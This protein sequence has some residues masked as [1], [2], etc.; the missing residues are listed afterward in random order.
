MLR[1]DLRDPRQY[2]APEAEICRALDEPD[3]APVDGANERTGRGH[4]GGV[5]PA[6]GPV[7][8]N[9]E[10]RH[11]VLFQAC[12]R[13]R[14]VIAPRIS[15]KR[16]RNPARW[17]GLS[18]CNRAGVSLHRLIKSIGR[19]FESLLVTARRI[20]AA[21]RAASGRRR[22][23]REIAAGSPLRVVVGS[24][25]IFEP[26]WLR[27]E[28][29][30]LDLLRPAEW[31][32]YFAPASIAA[33]L[34]EHVWEHLTPEQGLT[35]ARTC[36]EFLQPGGYLRLAVPDGLHPDDAYREWVRPGGSGAGADDHKV[37]Y[38][39][40][41]LAQMLA[42]AGFVVELLEY[43]DAAGN[44]HAVDWDPAAGMIH[45]SRR[46]DERNRAGPLRYTSLIVDARKPAAPE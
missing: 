6:P 2:V 43:F 40:Q 28:R 38:T 39:H 17:P 21:G 8:K 1:R 31:R 11:A 24:E 34:A 5:R 36:L 27:T 42:A 16:D 45:R 18:A 30:Y 15:E 7:G 4:G 46:F 14:Q 20:R 25:G 13:P 12:E 23:R 32:A 19:A 10:E 29:E 22:L 37:L 33:I 35:A 41:S 26:G 9:I 3:L 44:F